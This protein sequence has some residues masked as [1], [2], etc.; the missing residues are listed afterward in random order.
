MAET[1]L[2]LYTHYRRRLE[3]ILAPLVHPARLI[4]VTDTIMATLD[5]LWLDWMRRRNLEAV[6]NGL[7]MIG[8]LVAQQP[9]PDGT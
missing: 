1:E 2:A 8:E 4:P 7:R 3:E 9:R 5:G 6:D